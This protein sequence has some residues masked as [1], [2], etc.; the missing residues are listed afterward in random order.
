MNHAYRTSL[1]RGSVEG[2]IA[3]GAA[4]FGVVQF[5]NMEPA[6][7]AAGVAFFGMLG[8]RVGEAKVT[9]D[10]KKPEE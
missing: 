3:A 6:I 9:G 2:L 5:A 4:F 10:D 8:L 1:I 7:I